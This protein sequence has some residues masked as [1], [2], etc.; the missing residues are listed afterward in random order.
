MPAQ[1]AD[2]F[3]RR[4]AES[5]ELAAQAVAMWELIEPLE[6]IVAQ[7]DEQAASRILLHERGL[8]WRERLRQATT[9]LAVER[10]HLGRLAQIGVAAALELTLDAPRRLARLLAAPVQSMLPPGTGMTFVSA[11]AQSIDRPIRTY[12]PGP[13]A[14]SEPPQS[15]GV[16]E[17]ERTLRAHVTVNERTRTLSVRFDEGSVPA[18]LVLVPGD[19]HEEIRVAAVSPTATGP[20][21][22]FADLPDGDYLLVVPAVQP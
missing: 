14:A 3:E 5:E 17:S 13:A 10:Q 22:M 2:V 21:A 4:L 7:V 18:E 8:W 16:L 19:P 20:L 15:S 6:S 12:G 9:H 1:E 11:S